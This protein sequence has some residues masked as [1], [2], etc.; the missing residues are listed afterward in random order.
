MCDVFELR[1]GSSMTGVHFGI[2]PNCIKSQ[3]NITDS[4]IDTFTPI[5]EVKETSGW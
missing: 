2:E 5:R 1:K 4:R 3:L